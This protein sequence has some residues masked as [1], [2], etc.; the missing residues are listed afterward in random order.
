VR[1]PLRRALAAVVAH[2]GRHDRKALVAAIRVL[3][4]PIDAGA[5]EAL[6]RLRAALDEAGV[7]LRAI[8]DDVVRFE[9]H[10]HAHAPVSLKR[11]GDLL[12]ETRQARLA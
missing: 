10:G 12:A 7:R 9:L 3:A 11:L 5:D 4:A 1:E 6:A 2:T 8:D